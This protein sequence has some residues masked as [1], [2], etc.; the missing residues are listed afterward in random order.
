M[1]HFQEVANKITNKVKDIRAA[2]PETMQGFYQM[3]NAVNKD[4]ALSAKSKELMAMAIGIASRCQGCLA[5]HAKA[6]VKLGV[7]RDEFMEMLQVAIYMG[8]G[9][10]L[11]TAAEALEA[12]DE[13]NQ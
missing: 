8:G 4:G 3:S 11:M 2:A 13:F 6:C 7:T 5:F 1:G 12:F 10:S 9:P